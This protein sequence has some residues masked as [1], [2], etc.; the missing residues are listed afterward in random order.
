MLIGQPQEDFCIGHDNGHTVGDYDG[1]A[2]FRGTIAHLK[3]V[4]E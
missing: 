1:K 3:V 2:L 4:T